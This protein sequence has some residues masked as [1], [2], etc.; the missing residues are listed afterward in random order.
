MTSM[1]AGSRKPGSDKPNDSVE[2]EQVWFIA[3]A[4]TDANHARSMVLSVE[5]ETAC[6]VFRRHVLLDA[7]LDDRL[8]TQRS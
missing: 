6:I 1:K 7:R 4:R 5:Q 8:Y 3:D 2:V